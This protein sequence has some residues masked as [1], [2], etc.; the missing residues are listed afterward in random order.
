V[1]ASVSGP[2]EVRLA[3]EQPSRAT[4][5]VSVRPL[6]GVPGTEAKSLASSIRA[7]LTP[8]LLLAQHPRTLIQL[9]VQSLTPTASPRPPPSLVASIINAST[10]A[11]LNTGSVP[12]RGVVCAVSVGRLHTTSMPSV[13]YLV[14]DPSDSEL[15]SATASGC[16]AFIFAYGLESP[17]RSNS[18][19]YP[20]MSCELVWSNWRAGAFGE[21]E[22]IRAQELAKVGAERVWLAMKESIPS[23]NAQQQS[24]WEKAW[25]SQFG[26]SVD[27]DDESME[28]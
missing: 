14:L 8:S 22:L 1:L 12:M 13:A 11:V 24:R 20:K 19:G 2:I 21:E 9:V 25:Q 16:F 4:F 5:E 7:A 17:E 23:M 26:V 18:A 27:R 3:A 10:A 6:S 15:A 28:M